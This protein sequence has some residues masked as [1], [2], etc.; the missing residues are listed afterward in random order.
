[1]GP[2]ARTAELYRALLDRVDSGAALLDRQGRILYVNASLA[3]L[4]GRGAAA[5]KGRL[6]NR[7]V[8]G[9]DK[10]GFTRLLEKSGP[11]RELEL[12]LLPRKGAPVPTLVRVDRVGPA[13]AVRVENLL[14]QKRYE[15]VLTSGRV[16]RAVFNEVAEAIV[17][18]SKEGVVLRASQAAWRLAGRNPLG[19]SLDE[20]FP[21]SL[22]LRGRT[23]LP[24][25]LQSTLLNAGLFRCEAV[26]L[27]ADGV[28]RH[29]LVSSRRLHLEGGLDKGSVVVMTDVSEA[30]R[31]EEELKS[32]NESLQRRV[33]ER[34]AHLRLLYDLART[35]NE[36]E[37][38]GQALSLALERICRHGGWTLGQAYLREGKSRKTLALEVQ[39]IPPDAAIETLADRLRAGRR[40]FAPNDPV[41]LSLA[42]GRLEWTDKVSRDLGSRGRVAEKG[43]LRCVAAVPIRRGQDVLGVLE[44]FCRSRRPPDDAERAALDAAGLQLGEVVDRKR[45]QKEFAE[46]V[47]QEHASIGRELHDSVGQELTGLALMMRAMPGGRRKSEAVT[48]EVTKGLQRVLREVHDLSRG[49]FPAELTSLGL[50]GGIARLAEVTS[51]RSGFRC[52]F[53]NTAGSVALNPETTLQ[54]F[55]IA[56]E[57]VNNAVKYSGGSRILIKLARHGNAL[58]LDVQDD[59][60][61]LPS[62]RASLSGSGL[63][64]MRFRAEAIGGTLRLRRSRGGGAR[65]TCRWK[66]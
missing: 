18:L 25:N 61:G 35:S 7:L 59:G 22:Q 14:L 57:A 50:P 33:E 29:L 51:R 48:K 55:R 10:D 13:V 39:W 17:V 28:P 34:T 26:M 41:R 66:A 60:R 8:A 12:Y 19:R 49:V 42:S 63:R 37:S 56:Q 44:L 3:R 54:V 46:A 47:S 9:R 1:M 5:L 20:A 15:G 32:A 4:A 36:A 40:P 23:I 2:T 45:L 21:L 38:A 30:K 31:F 53:D 43:G 65:I 62:E 6:F 16:T 52:G 58:E 64:I 24:A 11:T 27:P